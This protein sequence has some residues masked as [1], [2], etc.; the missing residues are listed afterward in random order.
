MGPARSRLLLT[1][2]L[3][4]SGAC[5]L[6]S[7]GTLRLTWTNDGVEAAFPWLTLALASAAAL[8]LAPALA[9]VSRPA[10]RVVLI[11]ALLGLA[12]RAADRAIYRLQANAAGLEQRGLAGSVSVSWGDVSGVESPSDGIRVRSR[13]GATVEIPT[14][15]L[16][17][18]DRATLERTFARR[19]RESSA[20][21]P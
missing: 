3:L 11:L 4:V 15:R 13:E 1:A 12:T 7:R 18:E 19:I 17:A 6:A 21:R 8:G 9:V 2:C 5:L 10:A 20:A 16:R 14:A